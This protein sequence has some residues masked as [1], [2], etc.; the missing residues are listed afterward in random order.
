MRAHGRSTPF[1]DAHASFKSRGCFPSW[2]ISS[3]RPRL[4]T[5]RRV[6]SS[7]FWER[8]FNCAENR[9]AG[10]SAERSG[11]RVRTRGALPCQTWLIVGSGALQGSPERRSML[12]IE[13]P[14]DDDGDEKRLSSIM[15][16]LPSVRNMAVIIPYTSDIP[17]DPKGQRMWW[18]FLASSMVTFFGGLF[19]I[20]LWRTLNYL[21]TVCCHCKGK[22]KV[23]PPMTPAFRSKV[24]TR[25]T[26]VFMILKTCD[27]KTRRMQIT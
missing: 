21:W 4:K 11:R 16:Y 3:V 7:A 15:T 25:F 27:L 6:S 24:W 12:P 5:R 17:C 22:K 19:I 1:A 8:L 9:A 13:E 20:L 14:E 2:Y 18:A 23:N 10:E 26:D